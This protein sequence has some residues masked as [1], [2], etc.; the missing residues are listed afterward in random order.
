MEKILRLYS[1]VGDNKSE[2]I[3]DAV[4]RNDCIYI[5]KYYN[6]GKDIMV[7]YT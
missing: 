3:V 5:I 6:S 4:M 1:S 2:N 7:I